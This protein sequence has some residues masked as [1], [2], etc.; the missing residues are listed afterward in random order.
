MKNHPPTAANETISGV[1][2]KIER[3][4]GAK[5]AIQKR[6][7]SVNVMKKEARIEITMGLTELKILAEARRD[8][9]AVTPR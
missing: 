7:R 3:G 1:I 5:V 9:I 6:K 2:K 8:K 4:W